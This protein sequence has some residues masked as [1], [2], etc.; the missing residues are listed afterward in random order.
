MWPWVCFR[1]IPW[2]AFN[3]PLGHRLSS[4]RTALGHRFTWLPLWLF[5][6]LP[7]LCFLLFNCLLWLIIY[8][9]FFWFGM[10]WFDWHGGKLGQVGTSQTLSDRTG[11][12]Y[13]ELNS[14]PKKWAGVSFFLGTVNNKGA[15]LRVSGRSL[16]RI[17]F[18]NPLPSACSRTG[19]DTI[20]GE[21]LN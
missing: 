20:W 3:L 15:N 14:T 8:I 21:R 13:I 17:P 12:M 2:V 16:V 7:Q 6:R 9:F 5:H 18:A 19:D 10:V 1:K 4:L 11:H